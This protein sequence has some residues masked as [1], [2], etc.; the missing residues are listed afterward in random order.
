MKSTKINYKKIFNPDNQVLFIGLISIFLVLWIILYAIPDLLSSLFNTIL[1]K[2]ILLLTIILV[3]YKNIKYGLL[4]FLIL[5]IIYRLISYTQIK[6][7]FTWEQNKINK[8]LEIQKSI[9][10]DIVFDVS[11]VQK[12]ASQEEVDYF[13][14]HGYWKWSKETDDLYIKT[15]YNNPYVRTDP[16]TALETMRTIYNENAILQLLSW[17]A[18]EGQFLRN[19]VSI[20]GGEINKYQALPNGWG[21]YAFDSGQITKTDNI[22]KCGYNKNTNNNTMDNSL[23]PQQILFMGNG[24]ILYE[25]VKKIVPV[26]YNNLEKL[27]PGFKFLKNPCNPC[28]A[29]E[30]PPNYNC[31]FQLDISGNEKGVSPIWNYLW[32]NS[33]SSNN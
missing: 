20:Y 15:L 28:Q 30:N 29:L 16:Q 23:S 2:L 31:P 8:F 21:D 7:G 19:G 5:I 33:N 25:H 32:F 10:P 4:L 13:I 24:G 14:K 22:I 1:G 12:Q 6:E 3:S 18:K 26:D 27:I 17:Q 9:N 11:E